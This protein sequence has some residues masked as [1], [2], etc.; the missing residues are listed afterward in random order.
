[1]SAICTDGAKVMVGKNKGLVGILNKNGI[2]VPSFHC[3]IHQQALFSKELRMNCAMEMAVKII[4]R[5]KGGHNALTH[6]IFKT[7]LQELESDYGD[8]LLYTEVRWLSRGKCLER[9][10]NLREEILK[11]LQA[12]CT[13]A[14]EEF[15]LALKNIKYIK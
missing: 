11:F 15:I 7:F 12:Q 9:F 1:M 14:D 6:R 13:P 2:N 5:I 3:I 8:L 10:F 4:N